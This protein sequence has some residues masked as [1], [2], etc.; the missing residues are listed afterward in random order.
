MSSKKVKIKPNI[1]VKPTSGTPEYCGW[2]QAVKGKCTNPSH[3]E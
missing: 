2:C 1:I 3:K